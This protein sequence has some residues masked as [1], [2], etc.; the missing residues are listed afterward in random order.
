MQDTYQ[1]WEWLAD[2]KD[3]EVPALSVIDLG[4]VREVKVDDAKNVSIAITPT[5]S[6]CPAMDAIALGI[7]MALTGRGFGKIAIDY[8]LSPPWTT[9]WLTEEGKRKLKAYG[10]APP[11]NEDMGSDTDAL[12]QTPLVPCPRC[13]SEET[14]LISRYGPTA[15]KA[16]YQCQTCKEPFE[17]FKCH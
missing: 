7:R 5:Y 14:T 10:I 13:Q 17:Y 8:Q 16:L 12:F 9:D 6:G 15:C 3:P 11:V 1:I 2:V 4:I